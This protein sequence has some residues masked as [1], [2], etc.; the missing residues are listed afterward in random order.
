MKN[1]FI[2]AICI[3]LVLIISIFVIIYPSIEFYKD[4][5]LYLMSYGKDFEYSEDF[6]EFDQ[7]TCYDESYSYNKKRNISISSWD[8][9]G[10]LFFRWFR[11]KY[12]EGN[13]CETE[14]VLEESYIKNFIE[15]A[16]IN[17]ECDNID[18]EFL[19]EG[20]TPIVSNKRYPLNDEHKYINYILDGKEREM[21][22]YTNKE[23][24]I[25][26]QVGLSDEGPKYIAYK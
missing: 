23:G 20:K 3:F 14:Y 2:L 11:V 19:I 9:E 7:E 8:Y 21:F 15:N 22:I 4:D 13:V 10:F 16:K 17:D 12:K 24:L 25:I 18:L 5:Y 26:I 6:E 1:K